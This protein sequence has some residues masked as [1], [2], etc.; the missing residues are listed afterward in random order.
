M[1]TRNHRAMAHLRGQPWAKKLVRQIEQR[2][3][4]ANGTPQGDLFE[5]RFG[6]ELSFALP[7]ANLVYEFSAKEDMGNSNVDFFCQVGGR[8]WLFECMAINESKTTD[9]MKES[10]EEVLGPGIVACSVRYDGLASELKKQPAGELHRVSQAIWQHVWDHSKAKPRKF[11][12]RKENQAN[13]L[14][15]SMAG[16]EFMGDPDEY[17]CHEIAYGSKSVPCIAKE[18]DLSGLFNP[19]NEHP[20]AKAVQD[21]VDLLAFVDDFHGD[22]DDLKIRR[23]SILCPNPLSPRW[24]HVSYPMF[25]LL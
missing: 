2:G 10:S 11:P 22:Y 17:Q 19:D 8:S 16:F 5:L 6:W 15:I 1:P 3:G 25:L 20:G 14:V 12:V 18:A 24:I 4:I 13:V 7:N 21:R 23:S 9:E